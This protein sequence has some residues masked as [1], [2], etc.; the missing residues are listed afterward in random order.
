MSA[1]NLIQVGSPT[2]L[3]PIMQS[4]SL[5]PNFQQSEMPSGVRFAQPN[6][7]ES[8]QYSQQSTA[9]R[10]QYAEQYAQQ[11]ERA[12]PYTS[13]APQNN[14][15]SP[16]KFVSNGG[17]TMRAGRKT[18]GSKATLPWTFD[19]VNKLRT[20][21]EYAKIV[22]GK[23]AGSYKKSNK[24]KQ[25]NI[26]RNLNKTN[27]QQFAYYPNLRLAGNVNDIISYLNTNFNSVKLDADAGVLKRIETG[28]EPVYSKLTLK[29][30]RAHV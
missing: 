16:R 4:R 10:Q 11:R 22:A 30:G 12:T 23:Q 3:G 19:N 13:A 20:D 6:V 26:L 27:D 17:A 28:E 25:S 24:L 8:V 1:N 5:S 2:G 21:L 15:V 29:I 14:N 18:S 7:P 9:P